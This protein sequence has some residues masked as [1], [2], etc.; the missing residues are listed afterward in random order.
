M[1]LSKISILVL[2]LRMNFDMLI[3]VRTCPN[4]SWTSTAERVMSILNLALQNV[5]L[6]RKPMDEEFE[7]V[8][9]GKNNVKNVRSLFE[10]RPEV[11]QKVKE[12]LLPV[13]SLL[14]GLFKRM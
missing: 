3:A 1:V 9:A 4:Q 8:I 11:E 10:S 12:S 2:F 6:E 5:S 7:K 14:D 13:I